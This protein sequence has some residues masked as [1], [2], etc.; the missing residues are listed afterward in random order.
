MVILILLVLGL[1]FGSFVNAL[2]WRL[3]E[4]RDW[5]RGRSECTHCHHALAAKDLIPVL[6]WLTLGGKCRYC[7][8][9]I[10]DTPLVEAGLALLFVL[11]YIYWPANLHGL[12]VTVFS[13]WLVLLIGLMALAVYDLRWMLLPNKIIF[14]LIAVAIAQALLKVWGANQPGQTLIQLALASLIGGGIFYL[15]F[16]F[17]GGR[18]IGGGDVK[19]GFLLGLIVASPVRSLLLIFLA[20]VFGSLVSLPLVLNKRL[21]TSSQIPFGPFLIIAAIVV[22]LFGAS[23]VAWYQQKLLL[24]L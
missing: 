24:S 4:G 12:E 20:S 10:D 18:W 15:V 3:R 13:L 16:Q 22:Q 1:C 17:S 23:L 5:V 11:S 19:L 6:S 14:P 21:K 9:P 2:V 8:Q 7:H